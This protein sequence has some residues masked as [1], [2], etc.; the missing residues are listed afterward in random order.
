VLCGQRFF[1]GG[2]IPSV[3]R[4]CVDAELSSS[5]EGN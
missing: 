1:G 4:V 5:R 2:S 3:N